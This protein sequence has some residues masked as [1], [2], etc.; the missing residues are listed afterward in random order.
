MH[1]TKEE[2]EEISMAMSEYVYIIR[3]LFTTC[4]IQEIVGKQQ[5]WERSSSNSGK[6]QQREATA[7]VGSNSSSGLGLFNV[8]KEMPLARQGSGSRLDVWHM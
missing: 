4:L 1:F 7:A 8:F 6:Q 2:M 5:Q 3:K